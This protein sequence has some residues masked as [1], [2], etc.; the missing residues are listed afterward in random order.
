VDIAVIRLGHISNFTDFDPLAR[1]K[2]VRLRYV[3]SAAELGAPDLLIIPGSKNTV[4]DM[5]ALRSSGLEEATRDYYRR[6]GR[7]AG[8]CG[9]YQMLGSYV[10]DPHG[11]ETDKGGAQGMRLLDVETT[12][13]SSKVTR[14]VR[15]RVSGDKADAGFTGYEIHMGRTELGQGVSPM[16]EVADESGRFH[17]DGAV[18]SDGRVWGTY[19]HGI[20]ENDGFRNYILDDIGAPAGRPAGL[21]YAAL[22]QQGY[23][24]LADHIE[25][26]VDMPFILGE[27]GL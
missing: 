17:D 18:S 25:M 11:V 19:I 15:A 16:F 8:I 23:E 2:G 6:G 22:K 9:G 7:I 5:L 21:N 1:E 27:L 24:L 20:F 10:H 26:N 12:L 13:E 3:R 14:Q 4:S